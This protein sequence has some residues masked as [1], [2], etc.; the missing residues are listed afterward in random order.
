[1]TSTY[2]DTPHAIPES[3]DRSTLGPAGGLATIISSHSLKYQAQHFMMWRRY[4][5]TK[6]WTWRMLWEGRPITGKGDYILGLDQ[7]YFYSV[8][9]KDP[10]MTTGHRMVLACLRGSGLHQNQRYWQ[11]CMT[12]TMALPTW[13]RRI[14]YLK[15][16][17]ISPRPTVEIR[18][19][20]CNGYLRQ[21][22]AWR[23][24]GTS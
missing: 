2:R 5:G 21:R 11:G 22:G 16:S 14:S 19:V 6:G 8:S 15:T 4:H 23:T 13:G 9:V 20:D 1:M 3:P 12:W 7:R 10:R 17:K 18:K 24:I